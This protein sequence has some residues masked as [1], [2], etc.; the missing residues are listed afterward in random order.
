[1]AGPGQIL[2]KGATTAP[3]SAVETLISS[4]QNQITSNSGGSA[5]IAACGT[6]PWRHFGILNRTNLTCSFGFGGEGEHDDPP[7][8]REAHYKMARRFAPASALRCS[9][10]L[11]AEGRGT[12]TQPSDADGTYAAGTLSE[13]KSRPRDRAIAIFYQE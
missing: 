9:A 4:L 13:S 5:G 7:R 10:M 2:C 3:A 8:V 6:F 11:A 12:V 1:M